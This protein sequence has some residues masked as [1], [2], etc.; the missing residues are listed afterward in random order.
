M[1]NISIDMIG[2]M[3]AQ[4][5]FST[6]QNGDRLLAGNSTKHTVNITDGHFLRRIQG[7]LFR[8]KN[9]KY[10]G[11]VALKLGDSPRMN[12]DVSLWSDLADA[13]FAF[14]I[15]VDVSN[16]IGVDAAA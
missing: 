5:L 14:V 7:E 6:N 10:T 11:T 16:L 15:N 2:P 9:H 8:L 1:S 4:I 13:L 12:L 3:S